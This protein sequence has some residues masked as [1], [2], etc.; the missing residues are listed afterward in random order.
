MNKGGRIW[1][2]WLWVAWEGRYCHR[3]KREKKKRDRQA[4]KKSLDVRK[5]RKLNKMLTDKEHVQPEFDHIERRLLQVATKGVVTLFNAIANQ[6]RDDATDSFHTLTSNNDNKYANKSTSPSYKT[7][8]DDAL[9]KGL[10]VSKSSFLAMV[11]QQARGKP[12]V[13]KLSKPAN[14]TL[15]AARPS[16]GRPNT[17]LSKRVKGLGSTSKEEVAWSVLDENLTLT[18]TRTTHWNKFDHNNL[19]SES[20]E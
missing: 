2:S 15:T 19:E 17:K 18:G 5:K 14:S 12:K 20:D 3:L 13:A 10:L 9:H 11:K 16:T 6:Q 1:D 7:P 8:T 4:N